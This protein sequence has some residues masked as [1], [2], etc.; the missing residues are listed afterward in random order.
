MNKDNKWKLRSSLNKIC[1]HH[2]VVA[3][4]AFKK[5]EKSKN[6]FRCFF[7]FEDSDFKRRKEK[8]KNN[9]RCFFLLDDAVFDW[10]KK[11]SKNDLYWFLFRSSFIVVFFDI[12]VRRIVVCDLIAF[13]IIV[14]DYIKKTCDHV[15]NLIKWYFDFD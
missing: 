4:C 12:F 3:R 9:L 2:I 6:N 1:C 7:L 10:E 13:F 15:K 5:R 11:K 8:S 14:F